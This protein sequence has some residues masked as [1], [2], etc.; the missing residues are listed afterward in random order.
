MGVKAAEILVDIIN[1]KKNRVENIV[2]PTT[3]LVRNSVQNRL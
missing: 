2:F 1:S 3:L